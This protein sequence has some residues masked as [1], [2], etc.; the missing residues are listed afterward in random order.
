M[1]NFGFHPVKFMIEPRQRCRSSLKSLSDA[2]VFQLHAD[3]GHAFRAD[4]QACSLQRV[5]LS[6]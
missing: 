1:F 6:T 2:Q 4:G 5:G 3:N